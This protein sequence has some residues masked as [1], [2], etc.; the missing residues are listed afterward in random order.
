MKLGNISK[1]SIIILPDDN[2]SLS[3]YP[4]LFLLHQP[5]SP[6]TKGPCTLPSTTPVTLPYTAS[7]SSRII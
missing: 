4:L 7:P 5:L 2:F 3:H 6:L 1:Q